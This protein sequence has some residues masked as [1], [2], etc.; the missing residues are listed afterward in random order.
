MGIRPYVA[1]KQTLSDSK[2]NIAIS[3]MKAMVVGPCIQSI[4][5]LKPENSLFPSVGT[6]SSLFQDINSAAKTVSIAGLRTGANVKF[7]TVS[8]GAKNVTVALPITETYKGNVKSSTEKHIVKVDISSSG[9]VTPQ[10]LKSKGAE[11]RDL[12]EV[13]VDDNGTIVYVQ[14]RIRKIEEVDNAGTPEL[15]IYL[16]DEVAAATDETTELNLIQ[17]KKISE[18][19]L[20]I[21]S[22]LSITQH[23]VY[24]NSMVM[25]NTSNSVDGGFA[26]TYYVYTPIDGNVTFDNIIVSNVELTTLSNYSKTEVLAKV[27]DGELFNKFKADR[28]DLSNNI[29]E[30]TSSNYIEKLGEPS[31]EN[32]ISYAMKLIAD[33]VPGFSTKVYIVESDT[34]AAYQKALASIVTS[35]SFYSIS[36][37]TDSETVNQYLVDMVEKA[38]S[39]QVAKWK[40]GIISGRT[41]YYR[42]KI[43]LPAYTIS[44]I[45]TSNDYYIENANGGFLYNDVKVG[46]FIS[47][48]EGI[49]EA[50]NTYYDGFGETYSASTIAVVSDIVTDKKIKITTALPGVDLTNTTS[51]HALSVWQFSKNQA[52]IES[53]KKGAMAI[54]NK[55]VVSIFPD[56]FT[57]KNADGEDV[58]VP[59]YYAAAVTNLVMAHLPPQQGLSNLSYNSLSKAIG[60][61]F[62]FT[63]GELDEIATAGMFVI[64]QQDHSTSPYVLR[65]LTTNMSALET[66]E[67]NKVRCLDYATIQFAESLDG[68][69]GKR[70]VSERNA[71]QLKNTLTATGNRI[72]ADTKDD[73]L[74]SVITEY[75]I[76]DV[77]IPENEADAINAEVE[78]VTPTSLNTIRLFVS[79]KQ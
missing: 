64:I 59:G 3:T 74:G 30:V 19:P 10:I 36:V 18:V 58:I 32:K 27:I 5:E 65:Q 46:D 62:Y 29:F 67:I 22:P 72:I 23:P 16:W 68:Y 63:D 40:M 54:D 42:E 15:Y 52:L 71:D 21:L 11:S 7:D 34:S 56:K 70:N 20:S 33:E 55:D 1:I 43:G 31:K 44:Q 28:A 60:S 66:M 48:K 41:P 35:S 78:V 37:L 24:K 6:I 12:L 79:S 4:Q 26:C 45:G 73:N 53:V 49:E 25:D 76:A 77:Y 50:D 9:A 14:Y 47:T 69:V 8:F 39:E 2:A 13:G 17:K 38:G 61:S 51:G 57:V 75:T